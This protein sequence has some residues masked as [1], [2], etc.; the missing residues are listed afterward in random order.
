M[1]SYIRPG[2]FK[3]SERQFQKNYAEPIRAGMAADAMPSIQQYADELITDFT[4]KV[5]P[6]VH[7]RDAKVLL[8]ELP[9]LQQAV[10]HVRPTSTQK[11]L[12]LLYGMHQRKMGQKN[13][14][15]KFCAL[16]PIHNHPATILYKQPERESKAKKASRLGSKSNQKTPSRHTAG[17]VKVEM[18]PAAA[19]SLEKETSGLSGRD[20]PDSIIDLLSDSDEEAAKEIEEAALLDAK[21]WS[22]AVLNKFSPEELKDPCHGNK[23]ILVLHLLMQ[24]QSE[25]DKVL[26]FS[27][28]LATLDYLMEMLAHK[29]WT[30]LVSSL[31]AAFPN[32]KMGGWKEGVDFVRIDGSTSGG[33]RGDRIKEFEDHDGIKL[34][35]IS[36][37]AGSLGINLCAANRVILMDSHFN[38]TVDLQAIYRAYRYGQTKPVYCYRFLTHGSMEEK[39]YSRAVTKSGLA[40][41]VVDGKAF[42]RCFNQEEINSLAKTDDWVECDKCGRWRM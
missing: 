23:C 17:G 4:E 25:G 38:P 18:D 26:L 8:T 29:D 11:S 24:A 21:H 3:C 37:A 30:K 2:L 34:F 36:V 1:L 40:G 7:R 6:F 22:H 16:R 42:L 35:L 39:V 14:F 5:A 32:Q 41:S 28:S 10:L 15:D 12:F 33:D 20:S 31:Q 19:A 13:F 9:P 27:Q